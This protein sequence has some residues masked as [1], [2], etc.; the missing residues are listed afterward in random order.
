MLLNRDRWTALTVIVLAYG[1]AAIRADAE[2]A[3]QRWLARLTRSGGGRPDRG[4]AAKIEAALGASGDA[5]P[6]RTRLTIRQFIA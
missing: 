5:V 4:D 3:F 6:A 2:P 1:I